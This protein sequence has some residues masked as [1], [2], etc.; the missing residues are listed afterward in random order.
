MTAFPG[1]DLHISEESSHRSVYRLT[2]TPRTLEIAFIT[3]GD[4]CE[5]PIALASI[6]SK[7]MRELYMHAFNDYWSARIAGLNPTAGYY[8][9]AQRWLKETSSAIG[10]CG[11]NRDMLVRSR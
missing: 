1:Y 3:G 4:G 10:L 8:T 9:D 11:V 7:Y 2:Q 5:F 6:Y